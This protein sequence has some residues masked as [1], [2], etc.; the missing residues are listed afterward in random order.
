MFKN[1]FPVLIAAMLG[2]S[3]AGQFGAAAL[4][5]VAFMLQSGGNKK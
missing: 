5:I 4:G 1:L 3:M 2:Y